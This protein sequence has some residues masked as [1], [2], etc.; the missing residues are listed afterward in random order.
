ML[1]GSAQVR[2]FMGQAGSLKEKRRIIKSLKDNIHNKFNVS[3]AEV[4]H[5]DKWQSTILGVAVA[6]KEKRHIESVLTGV[7]NYIKLFRSC[8]LVDYDVEIY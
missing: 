2:L 3:V 1:V 7:I 8:Q 6:G 4:D 5:L